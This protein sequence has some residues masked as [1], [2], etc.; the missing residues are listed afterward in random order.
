VLEARGTTT[1]AQR[2]QQ[3]GAEPRQERSPQPARPHPPRR[4]QGLTRAPAA[5]LLGGC[6]G[7]VGP[8]FLAI[9]SMASASLSCPI[10]QVHVPIYTGSSKQGRQR[11][12]HHALCRPPWSSCQKAPLP[13]AAHSPGRGPSDAGRP[14][15]HHFGALKH[16]PFPPGLLRRLR[17]AKG[18]WMCMN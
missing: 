12:P 11:A 9:H 8:G 15:R 18:D 1:H 13:T 5:P 6:G 14:C 16:R 17:Q 3:N 10:R 7:A 2:R 4:V